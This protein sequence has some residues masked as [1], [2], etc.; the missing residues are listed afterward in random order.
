[1]TIIFGSVEASTL[2]TADKNAALK[3]D[4]RVA[5]GQ[6]FDM[7]ID[8]LQPDDAAKIIYQ[9]LYNDDVIGALIDI[10]ENEG[11]LDD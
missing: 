7:Y 6:L 1:M 3:T 10:L 9:T 2:L 11:F 4:F 8:R 5:L